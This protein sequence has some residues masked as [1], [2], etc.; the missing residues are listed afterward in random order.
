MT[1]AEHQWVHMP[2]TRT[3]AEAEGGQVHS[4]GCAWQAL[5]PVWQG[6]PPLSAPV[7]GTW[8]VCCPSPF[9]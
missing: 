3:A 1:S 8:G 9:Y 6:H 5:P 2:L 4:Q 7:A